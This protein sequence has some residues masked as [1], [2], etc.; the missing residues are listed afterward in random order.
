MTNAKLLREQLRDAAQA[1]FNMAALER[2]ISDPASYAP[3]AV[4]NAEEPEITHIR[5]KLDEIL[6]E[7][8]EIRS[9]AKT[10]V[11]ALESEI[12]AA[13]DAYKVQTETKIAEYR[14]CRQA[15]DLAMKMAKQL[16]ADCAKLDE[17]EETKEEGK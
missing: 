15:M 16:R 17:K 8:G 10:E 6:S 9:A 1:P 11:E 5:R 14:R 7:L 3:P 2:N 12:S 4:R 13:E